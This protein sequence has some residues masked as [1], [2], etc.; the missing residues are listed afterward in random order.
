MV[1]QDIARHGNTTW[2]N[3]RSCK[4][5]RMRS[6]CTILSRSSSQL[7]ISELPDASCLQD[8]ELY[9][10]ITCDAKVLLLE[11]RGRCN[12]L[13]VD[14]SLKKERPRGRVNFPQ[15]H[16]LGLGTTVEVEEILRTKNN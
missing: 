7:H 6:I 14:G 3:R 11:L 4:M 12:E 1:L 2:P 16:H 13:N 10:V 15:E 5:T 8:V 9:R